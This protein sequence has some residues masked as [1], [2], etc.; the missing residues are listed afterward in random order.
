M[1]ALNQVKPAHAGV[2]AY[3]IE[4]TNYRLARQGN[5]DNAFLQ[6]RWTYKSLLFCSSKLSQCTRDLVQVQICY[7]ELSQTASEI[8]VSSHLPWT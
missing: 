5:E 2:V 6:A 4:E 3:V 7:A 8:F 1:H